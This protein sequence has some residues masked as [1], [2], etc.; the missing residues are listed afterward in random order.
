MDIQ[1]QM[2]I[3]RRGTVE[4]V[5]EEELIAKLE[6]SQRENRPLKVKLGIDPSAPDIHLG[7][8]V[9]L[10]KLRAFQNLGHKVILILG[11]Y[12]GMIGDPTGRSETRP[13]LTYEEIMANAETYKKQFFKIMDPEKTE[14]MPNGTWFSKMKLRDVIEKLTSCTTVARMMEREDFTN[15][16]SQGHPIS[17]HEFL[18]A[19]MQGYDSVAIE[20]DVELG[21]TEQKFNILVGRDLQKENNQEPQVAVLMPILVGTDG[22]RK[23]SKSLGNYIGVDEPP[24]MMFNKVMFLPDDIISD[25]FELVTSVSLGELEETKKGLENGSLPP[26]EAKKRLAQELIGYYHGKEAVEMIMDRIS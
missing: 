2:R 8:T 14:I 17:I 21:A 20:A 9:V 18:Y 25:Y 6:R 4:I 11:D 13:Q 12:T 3:I 10:H 7:H 19:L 26:S 24:E 15:R 16:Y 1:E 22:E 5:P 23:M